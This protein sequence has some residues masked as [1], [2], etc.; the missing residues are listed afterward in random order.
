MLWRRLPR[1]E[2]KF[3]KAGVPMFVQ[4]SSWLTMILR[5]LLIN[6]LNLTTA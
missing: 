6:A 5:R 3:N 2:G 4:V 1:V